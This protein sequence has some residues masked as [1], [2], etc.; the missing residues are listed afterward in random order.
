MHLCSTIYNCITGN[1]TSFVNFVPFLIIIF[2]SRIFTLFINC[3]SLLTCILKLFNYTSI[4]YFSVFQ[5]IFINSLH[6]HNTILPH[7]LFHF[8]LHN[9]STFHASTTLSYRDLHTGSSKLHT[10]LLF[11]LCTSLPWY[12]HSVYGSGGAA[13]STFTLQSRRPGPCWRQVHCV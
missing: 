9:L 10:H 6:S 2:E 8:M 13:D 4:L 12:M 1:T 7:T 3:L 11:F 5:V